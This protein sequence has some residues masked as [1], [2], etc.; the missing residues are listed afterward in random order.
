[1]TLSCSFCLMTYNQAPFVAEAIQSVLAQQGPALEI[2]ISDDGS[3]DDTFAIAQREVA[4]YRG[5]HRVIL[6][7]NPQNL[8][9]AGNVDKIHDLSSGEIII[10]AAGDDVSFSDRTQRTL[11]AFA[12]DTT[13]LVCSP[14]EPMGPD[15][16]PADLD[17]S[18]ATFY[19]AWTLDQAASSVALYVGASG[20]WTR[21]LYDKYGSFHPDAYEDLVFGFR[22]ALEQGVTTLPAPVVRYRL[23]AGTTSSALASDDVSRQR[24]F[25]T[26]TKRAHLGVFHQR[27]ADALVAAY[28]ERSELVR[29][30]DHHIARTER[31]L[32]KA[33]VLSGNHDGFRDI[34]RRRPFRAFSAAISGAVTR[35]RGK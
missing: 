21:S 26:R 2:V 6:N 32:A 12:Q 3:T 10:V 16:E 22:A 20:A 27:R 29:K 23:G 35:V 18:G 15:G 30:L 1:M 7:Q 28:S 11:Q 34:A 8:G 17:M 24:A 9:L 5:P 13:S 31:K 4:Q 14:V 19:G 33:Y 25:Q